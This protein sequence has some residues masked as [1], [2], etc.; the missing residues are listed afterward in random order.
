MTG[1]TLDKRGSETLLGTD[2]RFTARGGVG[3]VYVEHNAEFLELREDN[4]E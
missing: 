2:S 4:D 3:V 1:S